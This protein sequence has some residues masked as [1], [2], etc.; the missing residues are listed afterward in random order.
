MVL[1]AIYFALAVI[2]TFVWLSER[3][4]PDPHAKGRNPIAIGFERLQRTISHARHYRDLFKFLMTLFVYS[5]GTTTIIHLAAVY[6]QQVFGFTAKELVIMVLVVNVTAAIG[7][8]VFGF[9]QDRIGSIKTLSITLTIWLCAIIIAVAAHNS[10]GFWVAGNVVGIAMGASG[11]VGRALV[12]QFS[13]PGRSGEF[14]GLWGVAVK[15]ATCVGALSFGFVTYITGSNYRFALLT[16]AVFF[17]G[18]L[19]L[20]TT[21]N[22]SRGREAASIEVD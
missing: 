19:I 3:A 22:E 20:L 21:V 12:S 7:A 18:G 11:S 8:V 15:L 16:T 9:V 10:T 2:P 14:L 1:C 6:A 17:I 5:C 4:L 13:P